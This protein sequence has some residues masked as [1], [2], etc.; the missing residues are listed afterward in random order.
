MSVS[1]AT[2]AAAGDGAVSSVLA[3]RA[4]MLPAAASAEAAAADNVFVVVGLSCASVCS[5]SV[6][7]EYRL[8]T[9]PCRLRDVMLLLLDTAFTRVANCTHIAQNTAAQGT[10]SHF[11]Q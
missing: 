9:R 3:S 4:A 5:S 10:D 1:R 6:C 2:A 7:V 8:I 11:Q